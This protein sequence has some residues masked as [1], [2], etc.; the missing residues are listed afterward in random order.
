M[1]HKQGRRH[2]VG[3]TLYPTMENLDLVYQKSSNSQSPTYSSPAERGSTQAIQ[4]RPDHLNRVVSPS[5]GLPDN[6]QQVAPAKH[7]LFFAMRF[8]N[9]LPLC[10]CYRILWPQQWMH[11]H[12]QPYWAKWWRSYRT[13]HARKSF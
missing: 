2:E 4:A 10:H 13:P 7:R 3:P 6:M 5:R 12:Q 1:I 11:S 8:N 9:K